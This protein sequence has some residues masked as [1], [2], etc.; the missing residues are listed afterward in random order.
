MY[1]GGLPFNEGIWKAQ[2]ANNT[3]AGL[4]ICG[5]GYIHNSG[6]IYFNDGAQLEISGDG[7]IICDNGK[8]LF[9]NLSYL[10]TNVAILLKN[11]SLMKMAERNFVYSSPGYNID[12]L[13]GFVLSNNRTNPIMV[14]KTS[15]LNQ[16]IT[17]YQQMKIQKI[18]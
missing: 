1:F 3:Y 15:H 10:C 13:P 5:N 17:S 7:S 9:E 16:S 2:N 14:D 6:E 4:S 12:F 11:K 8:I 18:K